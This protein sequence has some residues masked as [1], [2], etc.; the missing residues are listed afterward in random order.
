MSD[1]ALLLAMAPIE[2]EQLLRL[3][4]DFVALL[5]SDTDTDASDPAVDR[6][7]P[8]PYPEDDDAARDFRAGT[9]ADLLDRRRSD[10]GAVLTALRGLQTTAEDDAFAERDLRV[11]ASE[12]D[13]WLRTLTSVRL[14]LA[15]RLGITDDD[16]HRIPEQGLQVYEWIGYRLELL[17]Q[18]ADEAGI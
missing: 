4:T 6:L 5:D 7:T 12:I 9:R 17:L 8:S 2:A 11:P 13:A 10:A 16:D 18:A 1:G 14:V 3:L 15:S